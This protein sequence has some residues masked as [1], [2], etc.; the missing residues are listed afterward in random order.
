[1]RV[2]ERNPA[3]T[4]F[5]FGVVFSS[6]ALGFL[7][8]DD[9]EMHAL[10]STPMERWSNLA[11]S[12]QGEEVTLDGQGLMA[13]G[14]LE[15]LEIM[16]A[17]AQRLGVHTDFGTEISDLDSLDADV[18]IGA[19]GLNSIVRRHREEIY[20]PS[21]EYFSNRFAWF[22]ASIAFDPMFQTFVQT[23]KGPLNSHH[24]RYSPDRSTF[25]VECE[26]D[27]FQ[28]YGFDE[29]NE[30]Q[31]AEVC[32][33][34]FADALQG[35]SLITNHS[36]WRQFPRVWCE[37]WVAGRHVLLGDAARTAHFS[38]GSGTRLALDDAIA[39]VDSLATE[40]DVD[41]ALEHFETNR[42]PI[43]KKLVDAANTSARWY[44]TFGEKMQLPIYDFAYDYLGRTGRLDDE[45]LRQAVPGFMSEYD[46]WHARRTTPPE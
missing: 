3:G 21:I 17:E 2:T 28:A 6:R 34:I 5:G 32:S 45:K 7:E 27:T 41:T 18:V 19:D 10:I 1:M 20:Q 24:Y 43:A 37:R 4:T 22:G 33:E 38:V 8:R 46:A 25:I 39:L 16:R 35:T 26:D 9:P 23:D 31:S 13:I 42:R 12:H 29:M 30:E 44:E 36:I 11:I 40:S 14:R 15:L